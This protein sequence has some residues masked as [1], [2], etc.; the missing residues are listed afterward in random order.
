MHDGLGVYAHLTA[1]S[2]RRK[3]PSQ[4]FLPHIS[5]FSRMAYFWAFLFAFGAE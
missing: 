1:R 4:S 5:A 3:A 2:S